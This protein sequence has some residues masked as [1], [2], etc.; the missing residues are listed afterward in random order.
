MSMTEVSV[1]KDINHF[2]HLFVKCVAQAHHAAPPFTAA[3][4]LRDVK[5]RDLRDPRMLCQALD[6]PSGVITV[7]SSNSRRM[8]THD[9]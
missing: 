2:R 1:S 3:F 6:V 4:L 8:K 7:T 9:E 5:M